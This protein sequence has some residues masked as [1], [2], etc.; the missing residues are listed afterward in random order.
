MQVVFL[1]AKQSPKYADIMVMSA[2]RFGYELIQLTD[3]DTPEVKGVHKVVRLP[4]SGTH[5]MT[6]KLDHLSRIDYPCLIVDTDVIFQK[7]IAPILR[8]D[9]DVALTRRVGSIY[10]TDGVDVTIEMP[11]NCGVMFSKC[12][13][14]WRAALRT[15]KGYSESRQT[16]Y[17]DQHAVKEIAPR[18]NVL[19]LPC[20]EYNYTPSSISEDLS[21]KKIVHYKGKRKDWMWLP[22][23]T[24][25]AS[26]FLA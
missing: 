1:H 25:E 13:D 8:N 12:Q 11:Y 22:S 18:F 7:D 6:Y 16:W 24:D 20:S 21:D 9:F 4:W 3:R 10:D 2:A 15:C 14:F 19:E 26:L 17:G 23:P 5:V